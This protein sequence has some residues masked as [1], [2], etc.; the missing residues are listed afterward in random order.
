MLAI[1]CKKPMYIGPPWRKGMTREGGLPR[2]DFDR[3][4]E[5]DFDHAVGGH[6]SV[7]RG[8]ARD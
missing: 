1:G 8:G 4:L 6:G 7:C 3:L 5:F 2:P